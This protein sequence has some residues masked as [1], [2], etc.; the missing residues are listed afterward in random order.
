[1]GSGDENLVRLISPYSP[2]PIPQPLVSDPEGLT[3]LQRPLDGLDVVA[4]DHV[5]L[6]DILV[7]GEGHAAFLPG[8]HLPYLV[9]EALERRQR[10]LVDHHVVTDEAHFGAALH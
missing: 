9:L 10:A 7:V 5:A 3:P 1:M 8:R 4:L 6:A 2:L